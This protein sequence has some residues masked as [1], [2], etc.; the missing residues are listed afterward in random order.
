MKC[1][2]Q[3][4]LKLT[5]RELGIRTAEEFSMLNLQIRLKFPFS[6]ADIH[7]LPGTFPIDSLGAYT[8]VS[9]TTDTLRTFRPSGDFTTIDYEDCF[10]IK[11]SKDMTT[12]PRTVLLTNTGGAESFSCNLIES[13]LLQLPELI[14]ARNDSLV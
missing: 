8:N 5:A 3:D 14:E 11:W 10:E 6:V 2:I 13:S 12:W 1:Q 9:M 4:A 7:V